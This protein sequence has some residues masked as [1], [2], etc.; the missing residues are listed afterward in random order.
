L[1]LGEKQSIGYIEHAEEHSQFPRSI[2]PRGAGWLELPT[3]LHDISG[4]GIKLWSEAG[5]A[6]YPVENMREQGVEF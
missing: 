1:G 5:A 4:M 6:Y 3:E 2:R